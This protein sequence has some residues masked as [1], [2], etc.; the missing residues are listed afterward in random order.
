LLL[1][2]PRIEVARFFFCHWF[3][4]FSS[5]ENQRRYKTD[6]VKDAKANPNPHPKS[7]ECLAEFRHGVSQKIFWAIF[8]VSGPSGDRR[9]TI[10]LLE[11]N[12]LKRAS[13]KAHGTARPQAA[14]AR[15][16]HVSKVISTRSI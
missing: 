6:K 3:A 8:W 7:L 12:W 16:T 13:W 9:T 15:L 4:V 11:I 1:C 2:C 14:F 10:V 5:V